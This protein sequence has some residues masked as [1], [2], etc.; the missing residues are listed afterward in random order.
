MPPTISRSRGWTSTPAAAL[1]A[2]GRHEAAL[3]RILS[4]R[5]DSHVIAVE[6]LADDARLSGKAVKALQAELAL[7]LGEALTGRPD[8]VLCA[9]PGAR[10]VASRAKAAR[11]DRRG[12]AEGF[13]RG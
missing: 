12:A 13:L 6:K 2:A 8:P 4:Q 9:H 1:G 5:V 3:T 10:A 11:L 7:T